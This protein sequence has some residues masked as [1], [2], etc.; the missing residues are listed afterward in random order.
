M[1]YNRNILCGQSSGVNQSVSPVLKGLGTGLESLSTRNVRGMC[2]DGACLACNQN[3]G[4]EA[5]ELKGQNGRNSYLNVA[6]AMYVRHD[7]HAQI[8]QSNGVKLD[9]GMATKSVTHNRHVQYG[10]PN[11]IHV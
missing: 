8:V 4:M 6:A 11:G 7:R 3:D 10:Q 1:K 5:F 9:P 2:T